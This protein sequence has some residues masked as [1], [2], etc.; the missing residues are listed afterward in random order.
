MS[1][2]YIDGFTIGSNPSTDGGY[3]ITDE[4]GN[5][6]KQRFVTSGINDK[7]ITNNYTEFLSLHDCLYEF[8]KNGDSIFTDSTNNISWANL[9]FS[10]KSKR[11]DLI[12]MAQRIKKQLEEL[13]I[14]LS[15]VP[16]GDNWAG[17]VNEEMFE[18]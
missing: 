5:I 7:T 9:R 1:K 10:R 17:I 3:T 12:P 8:C 11:R 4:Y 13:K 6:L 15:W 18:A 2:Y 14:N 16:R